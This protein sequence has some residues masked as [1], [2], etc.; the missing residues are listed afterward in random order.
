MGCLYGRGNVWWIKYYRN[1]KP[2]HE[3]SKSKSKTKAKRLLKKREGEIAKGELPG[4]YFDKVHFQDLVNLLLSDYRIN[5]KKNLGKVETYVKNLSG[6]FGE[7][8]VPEITT[9][10]IQQFIEKRKQEGL[11]NSSINREI[12]ALKRMFTLGTRARK[13][14]QI[15]Y[16]P[17]LKE[18]NTRKG[19]FEHSE[20]LALKNALPSYLKPMV[21]FAYHT[22]WREGE[23]LGVK[24]NQVDLNE[25]TVRLEPGETKSGDART[26]FM[27]D[28]LLQE[29]KILHSKR[30]PGCPFVFHREGEGIKRFTKAWKTA[31]IHAGLSEP[32]KDTEGNIVMTEKGKT[33]E[34]PTKIFHDFRR[35]AVRNMVRSGIPER[36]AMAISGHKTRSVFERYN[37]VSERDLKE[38]S[39][40]QESYILTQNGYNL[41]T[42]NPEEAILGDAAN[43]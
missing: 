35:T 7:V 28:E 15:P 37:I 29:L 31:C 14:S 27:N 18:S 43:V 38:A 10:K 12:S 36:V 19:F 33:V 42:I 39:K 34:I 8:R 32:L 6:F 30:D 2:Y 22:G 21:V 24:W 16:V 9:D 23:I 25:R 20:F 26:V 4:I 1:G 5:G 40:R 3:S 13:V 41:V 17:M 11:E